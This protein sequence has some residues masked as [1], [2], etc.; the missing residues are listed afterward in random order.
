MVFLK[1]ST[2]FILLFLWCLTPVYS[3][4][5]FALPITYK[6]VSA[7]NLPL[8]ALGRNN[9]DAHPADIDND[10]DL[11]III[12]CEFCPNIILINDGNGNFSDESAAR[13]AQPIHDSEDVGVA[14]FDNNGSLD[15]IFVAEDDQI[16]ELY[17]NN[18]QGFFSDASNRLPVT[19]TSNAVLTA[20]VNPDS[21]PDILIGNAGQNVVLINDGNGN[22]TDETVQRLPANLNITQDLEWGDINGDGFN[23]I[24]EGNENGNRLLLNDGNGFFTDVTTEN[25]PLPPTGEETREADL[26]DVDGDGDLDL[27]F[28][29]VTFSQNRPAQNRLLL[30][31]STGKFIDVTTTH[32]PVQFLN[33]VDGDFVDVDADGDLDILTA[34]AFSGTYQAFINEGGVF[35]DLT[36]DVFQTLPTGNGIDVE[37]ADFNGDGILDIYLTGFQRTD[38]LFFG[39]SQVV[40]ISNNPEAPQAFSLEQNFPNPFNPVTD[41]GFRV[42]DFPTGGLRSGNIELI[43]YDI[44]GRQVRTL[45]N[46]PKMP[47]HYTVQWD[48]T[49]KNGAPVASGVYIYTLRARG[50]TQSRKM[51]LMR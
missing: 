11:D 49:D 37:A 1:C 12:A 46:E 40:A 8:K 50:F 21:F 23:D 44:N 36:G 38:F 13:I 5:N 26:G 28:A 10:G 51:V 7:T 17:L 30:N 47:G 39:E 31:D 27:F 34:Q 14:D 45:V 6:N 18:G 19:G 4:D 35:T 48:A 20:F 41:I 43:I 15:I 9:M 25:L 33:T 16:N 3:Q 42:T 2:V 24:V 32:L 29:N 22:F